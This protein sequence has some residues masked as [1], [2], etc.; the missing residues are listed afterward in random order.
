MASAMSETKKQI[1]ALVQN[2]P[3]IA[4]VDDV[5][6]ELCFTLQVDEGLRELDQGQGV[7]HEEVVA[8]VEQWLNREGRRPA[9]G[10]P[11]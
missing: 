4:T 10:L 2:L 7:P 11:F 9:H 8:R 1:I 3:D 5:S 6:R